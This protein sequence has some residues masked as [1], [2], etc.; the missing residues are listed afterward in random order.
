MLCWRVTVSQ[1][2]KSSSNRGC[3]VTIMKKRDGRC[4]PM[5]EFTARRFCS[6]YNEKEAS[7]VRGPRRNP[8]HTQ[9]HC[10]DVTCKAAVREVHLAGV[11]RVQLSV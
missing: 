3:L 7:I 9:A 8:H 10:V 1:A 5:A 4:T 2:S 6:H 11:V